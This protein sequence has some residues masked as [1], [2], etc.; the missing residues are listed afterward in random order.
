M[1][2]KP[3]SQNTPHATDIGL[4]MR[5]R[6]LIQLL[7]LIEYFAVDIGLTYASYIGGS[8]TIQPN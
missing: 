4:S 7:W 5:H 3:A 8:H 2:F 6:Y 1:S